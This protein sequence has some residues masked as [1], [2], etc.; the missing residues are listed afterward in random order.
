MDILI[1]HL[2]DPTVGILSRDL[3]QSL[4]H[5]IHHHRI[6]ILG[7]LGPELELLGLAEA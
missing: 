2:F 5:H 4:I 7:R 6:L 1:Y 3:P